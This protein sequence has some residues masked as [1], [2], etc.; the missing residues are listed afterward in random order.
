MLRLRGGDG[1]DEFALV[2]NNRVTHGARIIGL[3]GINEIVMDDSAGAD[4][5][6]AQGSLPVRLPGDEELASLTIGRAGRVIMSGENSTLRTGALTIELGGRLDVGT[7]ELHVAGADIKAIEALM[8]TAREGTI[9]WTGPGIGTSS[10]GD[11]TGLC[12]AEV[13]T[14]TPGVRVTYT[15]NGDANLDGRINADD[16]FRIDRGFLE[17]P[18][19]PVYAQGDLNYD[20]RINADDYFLID[21]AFLGQSAPVAPGAGAVGARV[22]VERTARTRAKVRPVVETVTA[23]AREAMRRSAIMRV[24]R[25]EVHRIAGR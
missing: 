7:G 17:Q 9:R 14:A 3:S 15:Y 18:P 22:V 19:N 2:N 16:Y 23:R 20:D 1:P 21:S 24:G 12:V 25:G 11:V 10:A 4:A 6:D 8:K 5:L 13:A